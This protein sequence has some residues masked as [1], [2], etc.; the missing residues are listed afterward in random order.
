MNFNL[1]AEL[2]ELY[3]R[4]EQIAGLYPKDGGQVLL[5]VYHAAMSADVTVCIDA[6]GKFLGAKQ[7][8]KTDGSA[9]TVIPVTETSHCRSSGISPHGLCDG[10]KYLAGDYGEA[11]DDPE[12]PAYHRAYMQNLK[13]WIDSPYPSQ[14]GGGV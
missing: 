7:V 3:D 11:A 2:L 10:L 12:A 8:D 6:D 5:P 1:F 9:Y 14:G 4:N 13:D